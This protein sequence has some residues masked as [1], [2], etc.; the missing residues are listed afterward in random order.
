MS[1][2]LF[3]LS[4]QS[5]VSGRP[6]LGGVTQLWLDQRQIEWAPNRDA[7]KKGT[8]PFKQAKKLVDCDRSDSVDVWDI[9]VEEMRVRVRG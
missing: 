9:F 6:D 3:H 2:Y 1:L 5:N 4:I 8:S 7:I